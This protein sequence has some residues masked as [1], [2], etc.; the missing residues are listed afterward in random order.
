MASLEASS[1]SRDPFDGDRAK[2]MAGREASRS[3]RLKLKIEKLLL[4]TRRQR[5]RSEKSATATLQ[6]LLES[7]ME[8]CDAPMGNIQLYDPKVEGL[9]ICVQKG[10]QAP[11]L[12]FFAIVNDGSACHE[13]ILRGTAVAVDDVARSRVYTAASRRAM[14]EAGAQ[15]VQSLGL[16]APTMRKLGAISVHYRSPGVPEV[17]REAL[18]GMSAQVAEIVAICAKVL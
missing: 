6:E 5:P 10:F 14:L 11:F 15:S 2:A 16:T 3:I 8:C 13:A 17:R 9:R 1:S 7:V 4:E 12:D 18:A